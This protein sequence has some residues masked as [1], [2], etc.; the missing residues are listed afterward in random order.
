MKF[1]FKKSISFKINALMI[2]LSAVFFLVV[3]ITDYQ[4]NKIE[5][6]R[7]LA[8]EL[9]VI[10]NRLIESLQSPLWNLDTNTVENVL[11][12][13]MQNEEVVTIVVYDSVT[14]KLL[15]GKVRDDDDFIVDIEG[16]LPETTIQK[17]VDVVREG[18]AIAKV[19]VR[20]TD[21]LREAQRNAQLIRLIIQTVLLILLFSAILSVAILFTII[22]PI[23]VLVSAIESIRSGDYSKKLTLDRDDELGRLASSFNAM[24]RTISK[25]R[26]ALEAYS[27]DLENKVK[28]RTKELEQKTEDL[29]KFNKIAVGRE[30][31]M[32]EL[33]DEIK[34]L[35]AKYEPEK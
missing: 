2:G 16:A 14:G 21:E 7:A 30:L 4:T 25:S 32:I 27:A 13:E 31:K 11:I 15:A 33:K 35:K 28:E 22:K 1:G 19:E 34:S 18:E 6:N 5:S 12:A 26:K 10:S 17:R 24:I 20:L 8:T 23:G 29:E 3:A 9:D